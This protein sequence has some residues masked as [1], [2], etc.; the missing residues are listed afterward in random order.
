MRFIRKF[1]CCVFFL[2]IDNSFV[3]NFFGYGEGLERFLGWVED[4]LE[5]GSVGF[6]DF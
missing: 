2:Y 1:E 5:S 3:F 6:E 4:K